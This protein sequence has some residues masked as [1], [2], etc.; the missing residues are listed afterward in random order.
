MEERG[1]GRDGNRSGNRQKERMVLTKERGK[2]RDAGRFGIRRKERAARTEEGMRRQLLRAG[3]LLYILYLVLLVY[4]LFFA[5]RYGRA[6]RSAGFRYNL[7]PFTEIR[8]FVRYARQIGLPMAILNLV[9]NVIGFMPLGAFLPVLHSRCRRLWKTAAICLMVSVE[10]ELVQLITQTGI[11]DID[12][13]LLNTLGGVLGYGVYRL[14]CRIRAARKTR[15]AAK[16]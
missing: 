14:C 3:R 2:G 7:V 5:E 11:C 4:F 15:R 6:D 16:R 8:R 9:G 1:Q 12:D 10:V 13:V